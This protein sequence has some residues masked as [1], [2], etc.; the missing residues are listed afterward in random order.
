MQ[1]HAAFPVT[2]LSVIEGIKDPDDRRRWE[3]FAGIYG[4]LLERGLRL[5]GLRDDEIEDV[6]QETLIRVCRKIGDY[7]RSKGKFGV[8]LRQV[9][10]NLAVDRVRKRRPCEERKAH[11]PPSD[12][13]DTATCD[14]LES[15]DETELDRRIHDE[16]AREVKER[17][18]AAV[19]KRVTPKQYQVYDAYVVRGWPV[20]KVV[21]TLGVTANQIYIAKTRVGAVVEEEGRRIAAEMDAPELPAPPEGEAG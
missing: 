4:P 9:A 15:P 12:E 3:Q 13:R 18:L 2:R 19:R 6:V 11:R 8:W 16:W 17:T 21:K 1:I 5:N 20:D 10:V 14:R 7:D